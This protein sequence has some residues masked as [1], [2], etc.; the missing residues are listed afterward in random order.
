MAFVNLQI[1]MT[2]L[3]IAEELVMEP[4]A[5]SYQ[6][7]VKVQQLIIW[8]PLL[9]ASFVPFLFAQIF[10]LLLIPVFMLF[11]A[12]IISRLVIRK[13][14]VKGVA[15]REFDI[16]YR[17]GLFWR[18]TVIVAFNRVQHVEVSSGPLQRKFGLASV[19]FFTAGGS[20][21]DL[22]VDGLTAKRA[23]EMRAFI[24]A[25]IDDLETE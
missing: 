19:K 25:K 6:R 4:M 8:L 14:Q 23:E 18:K 2:D 22:R 5:V 15:L 10:A 17:S 1:R 11:L 12:T 13:T 7:E 9:I 24:T 3:P 21:V 20:S 16:A